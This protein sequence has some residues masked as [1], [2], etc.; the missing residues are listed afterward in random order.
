MLLLYNL[1]LLARFAR[2]LVFNL[3]AYPLYHDLVLFGEHARNLARF[4][5]VNAG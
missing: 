3:H 1:A 5:T 2:P 4:A